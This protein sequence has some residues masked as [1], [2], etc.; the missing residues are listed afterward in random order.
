MEPDPV[1]KPGVEVFEFEKCDKTII[2][3][4]KFWKNLVQTLT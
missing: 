3:R 4:F 1:Q 2:E